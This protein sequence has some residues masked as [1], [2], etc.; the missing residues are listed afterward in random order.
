MTVYRIDLVPMERF[1]F[2]G[3]NTFGVDNKDNYFIRSVHFPQQTTLL[4]TLRYLLLKY[5]NLMNQNG[6][7]I[8][9]EDANT[10]IGDN[11]FDIANFDKGYGK[12]KKLSS[13]FIAGPDGDYV[14]QSQEFGLDWME[15]E[16]SKKRLQG[17]VPLYYRP[18]Q[19]RSFLASKK[20]SIPYLEGLNSKTLLPDLLLNLFTKQIRYL[21]FKPEFKLNSMNGIFIEEEQV[22]INKKNKENGF[23][24][25]VGFRMNEGY[26]FSFYAEIDQNDISILNLPIKMG[27]DQSWFRISVIDR[28]NFDATKDFFFNTEKRPDVFT[29]PNSPSGKIVLL[30]DTYMEREIFNSDINFAIARTCSFRYMETKNGIGT[31]KSFRNVKAD[32]NLVKNK[33]N[34]ELLKS[35]SVL[36]VDHA[37]KI[38]V[39]NKIKGDNDISASFHQIGYNYAI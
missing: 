27:A 9:V 33:Q 20:N 38:A 12:I 11:G 5:S 15:D 7:V 2:G 35:G 25:Q 8:N 23:Y 28:N 39:L 37:K 31:D 6:K 4:G 13:V 26:G 24:K 10:L 3:E 36:F 21:D 17:L 32:F 19:G 14:V 30:S 1:F 29:Y 18:Q 22:G 34:F 16:I